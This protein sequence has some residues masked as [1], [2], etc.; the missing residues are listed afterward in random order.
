MLDFGDN[1][2][3]RITSGADRM[4][5]LSFTDTVDGLLLEFSSADV[6]FNGLDRDDLNAGDFDFV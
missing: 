2:I 6:F 5:D 1:D 3:I 4:S